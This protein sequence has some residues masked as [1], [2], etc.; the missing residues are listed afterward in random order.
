MLCSLSSANESARWEDVSDSA[1][2]EVKG[3]RL[4][5]ET[6][7]RGSLSKSGDWLEWLMHG[8]NFQVSAL[9]W[10]I[11]ASKEF[12]PSTMLSL[13]YTLYKELS[14]SPYIA[15]LTVFHREQFPYAW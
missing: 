2:V 15:R 12:D 3:K 6:K 5:F 8:N 13:S 10:I 1:S 9:F 14:V 7:V 4:V 11:T